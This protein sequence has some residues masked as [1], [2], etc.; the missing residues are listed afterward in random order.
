MKNKIIPIVGDVMELNLGLSQ[1]DMKLLINEVS[2]I[3]HTAANVRFI[4]PI[5]NS[6]LMNVRGTRE[7]CYLALQMK[8]IEV[9]LK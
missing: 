7:V 4:E 1:E 3:F 5:K 9:L 8:R 2:V 6:V